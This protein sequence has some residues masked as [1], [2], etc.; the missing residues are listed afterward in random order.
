M[1]LEKRRAQQRKY[2]ANW[3]AKNKET[4]RKKV[5]S[6]KFAI[7]QWF[8]DYKSKL[9]CKNCDE[10]DPVCLDFHHRN[11]TTKIIHI[12]R[13]YWRGWSIEKIKE[14]IEKCD[15]LCANCHRKLHKTWMGETD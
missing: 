3:Y 11:P 2:Q 7:K 12:S 4:Q 5:H 14:E 10:S 15:I 1:D 13:I 8:V 9:K 6:R